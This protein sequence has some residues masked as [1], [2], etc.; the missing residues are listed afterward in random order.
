MRILFSPEYSGAVFARANDGS[1]V[2]MDTVVLNTMGLIDM[3][4]LRLG[5][6]YEDLPQNERLAHYYDAVCKYMAANP[7][8]IMS[9]SFKTS[10]LGTAKAMLAWR[11]ELRGVNWDF[12][13]AEISERLAVLIGVEEYLTQAYIR[14]C[15]VASLRKK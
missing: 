6:H 10:G 14:A 2:M 9:A 1:G 3:L 7:E 5:L 8:N 4:E 13:G 12:D 11:D 15:R